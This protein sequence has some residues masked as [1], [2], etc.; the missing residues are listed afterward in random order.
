MQMSIA[1]LDGLEGLPA[2]GL[3]EAVEHY[4]KLTAHIKSPHREQIALANGLV[5]IA[6]SSQ[7]LGSSAPGPIDLLIADLCLA[8]SSRLL[9]E[10]AELTLQIAVARVIEQVSASAAAGDPVPSIRLGLE[11]AI[12]EA[13]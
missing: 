10:S 1:D 12:E 2:E 5:E 11:R 13:G 6:T 4:W 7:R 3:Q 8:R 9:A